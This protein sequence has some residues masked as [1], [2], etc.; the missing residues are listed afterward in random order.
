MWTILKI[1][2]EFTIILLLFYVLVFLA[3]KHME[4]WHPNQ[5]LN[6]N[7]LHWKDKSTSEVPGTFF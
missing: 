2:I 6:R 7:P 1:F 3:T 5:E 4:S